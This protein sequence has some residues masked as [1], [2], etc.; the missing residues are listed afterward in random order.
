MPKLSRHLLQANIGV[1]EEVSRGPEVQTSIP[2]QVVISPPRRICIL[3]RVTQVIQPLADD[4]QVDAGTDRVP[5]VDGI[6][7]LARAL[8]GSECGCHGPKVVAKVGSFERAVCRHQYAVYFSNLPQIFRSV[9]AGSGA[10]GDERRQQ[11]DKDES[12]HG[13]QFYRS[14]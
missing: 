13:Q 10:C 6:H 12:A 5:L 8:L 9:G 7:C 14:T 2:G 3:D 11:R 4:K 1:H